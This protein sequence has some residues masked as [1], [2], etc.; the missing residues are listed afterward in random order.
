MNSDIIHDI[1][2][3]Q[4][5][6]ITLYLYLEIVEGIDE[7]PFIQILDILKETNNIQRRLMQKYKRKNNYV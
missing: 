3:I 4:N 1:F 5:S 2:S 6:L 7:E